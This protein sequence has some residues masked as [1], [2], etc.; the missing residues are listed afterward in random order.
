MLAPIVALQP[1]GRPDGAE[2]RLPRLVGVDG[3]F[4]RSDGG[5]RGRTRAGG[6]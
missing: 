5:R 2:A 6:N 4:A 1:A 3:L